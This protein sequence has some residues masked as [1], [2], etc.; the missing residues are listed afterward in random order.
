METPDY[1]DPMVEAE[2][3][4][5]A[6]GEVATY[7]AGEG[8]SHGS[9]RE[10]PA[11]HVA[12]IISVWAIE[13]AAEPGS[14]GWWGVYGDIPTD[15]ISA[16]NMEH[17]RD[18]LRAIAWRWKEYVDAVKAGSPPEGYSIGGDAPDSE[19]LD[20]LENRAGLLVEMAGDDEVWASM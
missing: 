4:F 1:D 3:C 8:L 5:K 13:S 18:V 17:P 7:L 20:L 11:W 16:E 14:V 6:H 12:P 10:W 19:L 9:V 15:Y 2:W